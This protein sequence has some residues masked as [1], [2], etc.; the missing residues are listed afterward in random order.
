M[1]WGKNK[2]LSRH[3]WRIWEAELKR[4][5]AS[6]LVRREWTRLREEFHS[7]PEFVEYLEK[8]QRQ[9]PHALDTVHT[10]GAEK[11]SIASKA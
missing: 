2:Y 4:T 10:A 11:A 8:A 9:G 6:T 5:L 3:V 1:V 7:Y